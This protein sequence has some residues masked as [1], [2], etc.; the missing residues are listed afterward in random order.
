MKP[1][2][3]AG[4]SAGR[5]RVCSSVRSRNWD[6][7]GR[8]SGS[9]RLLKA[10]ATILEYRWAVLRQTVLFRLEHRYD[11]STGVDGGFFTGGEVAPA[12]MGLTREQQL[13]LAP[14]VWSLDR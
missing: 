1:R 6:R 13:L 9:E 8:V 14:I 10:V 3:A 11:E 2:S 4:P 5:R 7:N 12:V